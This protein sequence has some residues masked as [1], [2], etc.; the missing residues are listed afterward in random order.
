MTG[1]LNST[2]DVA[3]ALT[4]TGVTGGALHPISI[5]TTHIK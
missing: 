5:V 1:V 3:L 4:F 2:V